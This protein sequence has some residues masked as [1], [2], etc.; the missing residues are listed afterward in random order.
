VAMNLLSR[1]STLRWVQNT[2]LW[3]QVTIL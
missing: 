3:S 2:F 1:H